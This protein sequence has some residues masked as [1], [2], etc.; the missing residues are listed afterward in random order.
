MLRS[1][2]GSDKIEDA[3]GYAN[4]MLLESGKRCDVEI[5]NGKIDAI[6]IPESSI[7]V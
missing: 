3:L 4:E 2:R 5:V 1:F 6:K 7:I